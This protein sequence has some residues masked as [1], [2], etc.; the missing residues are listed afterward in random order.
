MKKAVKIIGILLLAILIVA[1]LVGVVAY[2]FFYKNSRYEYAYNTFDHYK[3][4]KSITFNGSHELGEG[5]LKYSSTF[6]GNIIFEPEYKEEVESLI[7]IIGLKVP[8][9]TKRVNSKEYYKT[10]DFLNVWNEGT[11]PQAFKFPYEKIYDYVKTMDLDLNSAIKG[12][13]AISIFD[14]SETQEEFILLK[15]DLIPIDKLNEMLNEAY[16]EILKSTIGEVKVKSNKTV[17]KFNKYD[18]L[19]NKVEITINVDIM[20]TEQQFIMKYEITGIN[21][22]KSIEA[23]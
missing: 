12:I 2:S 14:Q 11:I 6:S 7:N 18:K 5:F 4:T 17:I 10:P 19:L 8:V 1:I 3:D 15:D 13:G 9:D 21:N 16:P 22:V 23:P 20:G